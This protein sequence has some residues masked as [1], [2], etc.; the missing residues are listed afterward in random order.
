[1]ANRKPAKSGETA[2]LGLR[3]HSGWAALVV[4]TGPLNSPIVVD[5][6]RIELIDKTAGGMAQPYHAAEGMDLQQAGELIDTCTNQT[7]KMAR[8]A[9]REVITACSVKHF[10]VI[11]CGILLGSGRP[12]GTLESTL[13]S[14]TLIHTAEGELYRGALLAAARSSRLA[15]TSLKERE[16]FERAAA[17]LGLPEEELQSRISEMGRPLGPPWTQDQKHATLIAWMALH[18]M[19]QMEHA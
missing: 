11:G 7:R 16:L 2:A 13:A 12:L 3:A 6:R 19:S 17:A 15:I 5:R 1:M 4:A 10:K 18:A 8:E 14:H 9:F